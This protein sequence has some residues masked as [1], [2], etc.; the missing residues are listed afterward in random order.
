MWFCA[1]PHIVL[2]S[3]MADVH[4]RN[5][6]S[7][8]LI[9]ALLPVSSL[10]GI[11]NVNC[12]MS[13]KPVIT[14]QTSIAQLHAAHRHHS[15]HEMMAPGQATAGSTQHSISHRCCNQNEPMF[16]RLCSMPKNNL[17]QEQRVSPKSGQDLATGRASVVDQPRIGQH[18]NWRAPTKPLISSALN[19]LP[20]PLRI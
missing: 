10:A 3:G 17:L 14:V 7:A 1:S 11:C 5:F 4:L 8:F 2:A 19:S 18:L 15:S 13:A 20:L 16:S 12:D 6:I 9:V